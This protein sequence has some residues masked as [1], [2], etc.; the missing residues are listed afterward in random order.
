MLEVSELMP[1]NYYRYGEPF[2]GSLKNL[3]YRLVRIREEGK[4][5]ELELCLWPGP[6]AYGTTEEEKKQRRRLP[7]SDEG[8]E[9][10]CSVINQEYLRIGF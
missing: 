8:L 10:A 3:R 4:E 6:F 1:L 5:D 7:F 9:E 2:T